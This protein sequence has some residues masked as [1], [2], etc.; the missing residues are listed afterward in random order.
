MVSTLVF[1]S[2]RTSIEYLVFLFP[3]SYI[4]YF[5]GGGPLNERNRNSLITP[6]QGQ[7]A[8]KRA[9]SGARSSERLG[10]KPRMDYQTPQRVHQVSQGRKSLVQGAGTA[11]KRLSGRGSQVGAKV[12]K[13][14]RPLGDKEFQVAQTRR[15]LDFLRTNGY[16]NNTLTSKNFPLQTREF[17]AVFNFIYNHI[18][19][20]KEEVLS[21]PGFHEPIIALLKDL[22][23]PGNIPRSHFVTLGSQH[24]W[25]AVLGCLSFL[26]DLATTYVMK[27][28]PNINAIGFPSDFSSDRETREKLTFEHHLACFSAFNDGHDDYD[29]QEEQLQEVLMENMG[30]D[31]ERLHRFVRAIYFIILAHHL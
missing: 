28:Q 11:N 10:A 5:P 25:P 27:L 16:H 3:S 6:R 19:P 15:I 8:V 31:I 2:A 1:R 20:I 23:Y 21:Y 13:D 7:G 12:V 14:T 18:D 17:V 29:E 30:V 22:S 26:C 4:M 24:S 9:S